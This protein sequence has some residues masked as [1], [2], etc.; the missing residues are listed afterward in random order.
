MDGM[1]EEAVKF[2]TDDGTSLAGT[3]FAGSA[4]YRT[5]GEAGPMYQVMQ[6]RGDRV[7]VWMSNSDDEA[8]LPLGDALNDPLA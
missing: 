1:R 7:L 6:V 3:P 5:I 2:E 4:K 8:E